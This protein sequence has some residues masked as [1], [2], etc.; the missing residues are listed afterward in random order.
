MI[1]LLTFLLVVL[2]IALVVIVIIQPDRSH[3]MAG[4]FGGG[5][6]AAIFGVSDDGGPLLKYTRI[7]AILFMVVALV[8]YL[9]TRHAG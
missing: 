6:Q 9:V 5:A 4:S 2:A 1:G 7:I 8:L 3:G